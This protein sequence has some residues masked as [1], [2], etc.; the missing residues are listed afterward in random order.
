MESTPTIQD[1]V[2][3]ATPELLKELRASLVQA[4]LDAELASEY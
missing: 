1:H 3:N 2:R 4:P